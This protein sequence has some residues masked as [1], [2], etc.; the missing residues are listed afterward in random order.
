MI[1]E[2]PL[3]SRTRPPIQDRMGPD[4]Q[5]REPTTERAPGKRS[6]SVTE[7]RK[8]HPR[9]YEPWTTDEVAALRFIF[10]RGAR[11]QDL[12]VLHG[13]QPSAIRSRLS[14]LALVKT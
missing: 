14:K 4:G 3:K 7:I 5:H 8:T 6:Y 2:Y 13:R 12:A 1:T 11:V 10:G 9:A